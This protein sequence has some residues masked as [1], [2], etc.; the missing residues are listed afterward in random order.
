ME[1]NKAH[2]FDQNFPQLKGNVFII[3]YGRTGSTLLQNLLMTIPE[4]VVRGENHNIMENIWNS[5]RRARMARKTW[6]EAGVHATHP[7]YGADQI[8]PVL[9]ASKMIDGFVDHVLAP[10]ADARWFGFKEIRYDSY[11]E[12]LPEVLNFM[13]YHFKNPIFVFNTRR[14]EDVAK[15]AWWKEWKYENVEKMVSNMDRRFSAY[16]ADHPENTFMT[17]FEEF[18]TN[19]QALRPLFEKMGETL[20]EDK[21]SA[22]LSNRLQH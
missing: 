11:G 5:A 17:S 16:H 6:K 7:W 14:I 20:D 4:C 9:L 18:S 12:R 10:P 1:Q 22:V 13:K 21:I 2:R 3:T 8:R 15:S 19:P